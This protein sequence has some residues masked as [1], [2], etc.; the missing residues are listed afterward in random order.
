[1][2]ATRAATSNNHAA[3]P[4]TPPGKRATTF[5][6]VF[7]GSIAAA[8]LAAHKYWPKGF[9]HSEKEDWELSDLAL[10]AQNR[11]RAERDWNG[12]GR[13]YKG[14]EDRSQHMG[15]VFE[16]SASLNGGCCCCLYD[17]NCHCEE[18]TNCSRNSKNRSSR[19]LPI[20]LGTPGRIDGDIPALTIVEY[21]KE[22]FYIKQNWR[23]HT[24]MTR[25]K[26]I[27]IRWTLIPQ[28]SSLAPKQVLNN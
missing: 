17:R 8:S 18:L 10:R 7:L 13:A 5:P 14:R 20:S 26:A 21:A 3:S 12:C 4:P 6:Y 23:E 9:P 15:A 25:E 2:G 11:R 1:M 27:W 16:H 28:G 22:P 24:I 19:S